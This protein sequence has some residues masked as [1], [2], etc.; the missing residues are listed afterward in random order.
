MNLKDLTLSKS[1]QQRKNHIGP[2]N[3]VRDASGYAPVR[4]YGD[5]WAEFAELA[6]AKS[7]SPRKQTVCFLMHDGKTVHTLF[8]N[9]RWKTVHT[10]W[11]KGSVTFN[12]LRMPQFL[13]FYFLCIAHC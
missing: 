10:V 13:A 2:V 9:A 5:F 11:I 8:S 7:L 3:L 12:F 6:C 4:K 1:V